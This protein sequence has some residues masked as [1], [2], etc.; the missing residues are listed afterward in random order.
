MEKKFWKNLFRLVPRSHDIDPF[1]LNPVA[2]D[3][4]GRCTCNGHIVL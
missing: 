1:D 2:M 3:Y 4:I